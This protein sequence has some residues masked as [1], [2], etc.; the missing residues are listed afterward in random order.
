MTEDKQGG[1][2]K[3]IDKD[4]KVKDIKIMETKDGISFEITGNDHKNLKKLRKQHKDCTMGM[5]FDQFSYTFIPTSLGTAITVKCSCGQ[6]LLIGD[7]IEQT[8]DEY[9]EE[10]NCVLTDEIRKNEHFEDE[11]MYILQMRNPRTFR[12]VFL[13]DRSFDMIYAYTL[14]VANALKEQDDRLSRCLLYRFEREETGLTD[15]Y[16]GLTEEEKIEKFYNYFCEH[17]KAF[18]S[19]YGCNNMALLRELGG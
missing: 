7:F 14:G 10:K 3:Y 6:E 12:M 5:A 15:Q 1:S 17:L 4:G 2:I 19:E 8:S 18:L 9:D 16:K 11:A 13:L